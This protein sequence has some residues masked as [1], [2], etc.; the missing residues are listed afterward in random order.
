MTLT[1]S[2]PRQRSSSVS[3]CSREDLIRFCRSSSLFF[4]YAGSSWPSPMPD[5]SDSFHAAAASEKGL[6]R[7]T[8]SE[9]SRGSGSKGERWILPPERSVYPT[10]PVHEATIC[11]I[12]RA[13]ASASGTSSVTPLE[14]P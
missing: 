3:T 7:S 8:V 10:S 5:G 11:L 13:T 1:S 12:T 2:W 9:A 14:V 6:Y 4:K